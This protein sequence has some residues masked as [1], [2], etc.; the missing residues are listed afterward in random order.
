MDPEI[1]I[2]NMEEL[3]IVNRWNEIQILCYFRLALRG[4]VASWIN[5]E[6]P[7]ENWN[8]LIKSSGNYL[9]TMGTK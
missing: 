6:D 3:G 7:A 8:E 1:Y 4:A 2:R 9:L 5:T